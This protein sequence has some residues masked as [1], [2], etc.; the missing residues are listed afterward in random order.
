MMTISIQTL[1]CKLNQLESE[2]LAE[3]FEKEG[4]RL[5][6]GDD[7]ADL[8]IINTCT[9][10]SKAEQ[11]ARRIIRKAYRDYPESCVIITGCYAQLKPEELA[12]IENASTG[13][14]TASNTE[15]K[16]IFVVSGDHK[17]R[18]LDLPKF[19]MQSAVSPWE[20]PLAMERWMQHDDDIALEDRFRFN[21]NSFSNHSRA[22][23]KI[24][25]GCNNA[26]TFC[27]V[28]FARGKSVSLD[29]DELLR[30]LQALEARGYGEAVLT[31][32]NINQY[33]DGK[34]N[35]SRLLNILLEG[36]NRIALRISS[37]EPDLIN[38]DFL[39]VIA[40][41]RIR[42]HFH[43]SV[44][45]GSDAILKTMRRRY[46]AQQV[47]H[48][49]EK[50]REV[51]DDPFIACDIICG[52]P[53]EDDKAFDETFTLCEQA[54]FSWIHAFPFSPRP[55]TDAARLPHHVPERTSVLR[56]ERLI[57]LAE[58]TREEYIKRNVGRCVD[59]IIENHAEKS[60]YAAGIT[61][62]YLRV[63]IPLSGNEV[64]KPGMTVRGKIISPFNSEDTDD[65]RID[66]AAAFIHSFR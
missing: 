6:S 15:Q 40:H 14:G 11:K 35:F 61:E 22:F 59:I 45:S 54:A 63:S 48:A 36:T 12:K 19:I 4:F 20:I 32:V 29:S 1:G 47:L 31:G 39:D 8:Y 55:G 34:N 65:A 28:H 21:A 26:C 53:G 44:Q 52:F 10:T 18:I 24:Q 30:R 3:A 33:D 13:S 38:A 66:A 42:P 60:A 23:L 58:K 16:R 27:A 51:K 5:V 64:L 50:L 46:T 9:V 62:N 49:I 43:L 57:Q 2:A 37:I 56:V 25:D 41:P 17:S 7:G